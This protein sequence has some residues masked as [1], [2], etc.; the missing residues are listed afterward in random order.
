MRRKLTRNQII[1]IVAGVLLVAIAVVGGMM[2]ARH[3]NKLDEPEMEQEADAGSAAPVNFA[4]LTGAPIEEAVAANAPVIAVIIP[5]STNYRTQSGLVE[6]EIV[7]EAIANG[8][9]PRL[10]A[11]Y[12]VNQPDKIGPVRSMR[13]HYMDWA[14]PYQATIAYSGAAEYALQAMREA[15]VRQIRDGSISPNP[16]YREAAQ[17]RLTEYTLYTSFERLAA[18]NRQQGY[19]SSNFTAWPRSDE[20]ASSTDAA[21]NIELSFGAASNNVAYAYDQAS[22]T[23][24]RRV[25]GQPHR[26]R[27]KGQIAPSVV[28]AMRVRTNPTSDRENMTTT[29][30]GDAVIFQNGQAISGRWS[31]DS[32]EAPLKFY[33]MQGN[34]IVLARGQTWVT[35]IPNNNRI[36]WR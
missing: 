10:M 7:Y 9:V 33:D 21:T 1:L 28:I 13:L 35:A 3:L 31:K 19:T 24:T 22:G 15:R 4:P 17:G 14:M 25:G 23:Y 5:N 30:T 2:V 27:E 34:E 26:D 8:G 11:F 36:F 6:A 29:G 12:Q 20:P 18:A 16:F 32:R